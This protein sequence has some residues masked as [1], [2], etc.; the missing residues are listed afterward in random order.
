MF[1]VSESFEIKT[2][3]K[4]GMASFELK[5]T[6]VNTHLDM[7]FRTL[8]RHVLNPYLMISL[9][10]SADLG[11]TQGLTVFG[12]IF[13]YDPRSKSIKLRMNCRLKA[14]Q[15]NQGGSISLIKNISLEWRN[16]TASI[17]DEYS[18]VESRS[19]DTRMSL[20]SSTQ[21][22][23]LTGFVEADILNGDRFTGI[24]YGLTANPT[25]SLKLFY[26][27]SRYFEM[28]QAPS[29][30]GAEYTHSPQLSLKGVVVPW[31]KVSGKLS[32][33]YSQML[34]GALVI[35]WLR[36]AKPAE[37]PLADAKIGLQIRVNM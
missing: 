23:S 10:R 35:D 6:T 8:G 16:F 2:R 12:G 7:G 18:F 26:F 13:H 9:P 31:A 22:K 36:K 14:F 21:N 37:N 33:S 25:A 28:S 19:I 4:T 32:F 11:V 24:S 29:A 15:N 1:K 17:Y 30:Y 20:A 27:C 3:L 5:P 34:G